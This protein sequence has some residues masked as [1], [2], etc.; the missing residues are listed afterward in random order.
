ML[1]RRSPALAL[2]ATMVLAACGKAPPPPPAP[3]AAPPASAAPEVVAAPAADMKPGAA[4]SV[5]EVQIGTAV[6]E[7]FRITAPGSTFTSGDTII[8]AITLRN[9]ATPATNGTVTARWLGPDGETFNEESQQKDF[10]GDTP[11]NFRI[12]EPKGFKP[13]N[14]TLEVSLNGSVVE[15]RLFTIN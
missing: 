13:G 9:A 7:D 8:V 2:L 12:A 6:G 11:V 14:Y 3:P 1:R 15:T 5:T 10:M 4:L